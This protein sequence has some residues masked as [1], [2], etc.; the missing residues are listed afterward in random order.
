[1]PGGDRTG[2]VGAGP[3]TG[4]AAGFCA[5][6]GMPGFAGPG[7]GFGRG[8]GFGRGGGRGWRHRYYAAGVPGRG[9]GRFGYAAQNR[10]APPVDMPTEGDPRM[11]LADLKDQSSYLQQTLDRVQRRIEEL[12]KNI[13]E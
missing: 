2:P 11:E 12:E 1:M 6:Y 10:E 13:R 9:R 8:M 4:R 3:R 5:G 7:F